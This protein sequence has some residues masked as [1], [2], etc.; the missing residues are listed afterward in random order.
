M[1]SNSKPLTFVIQATCSRT[2]ARVGVIKFKDTRPNREDEW[3]SCSVET[4][5]FMPVGTAGTMKGLLPD[6]VES[7]G[8]R[9]MLSNT[10]HLAARPGIDVIEKAGGLHQYMKWPHA[11]LTDSGGFQMVSLS[12]L[13]DLSEEGVNF[14]SPY[15]PGKMLNLPPEESIRVQQG[16]GSNIMMQLDDVVSA[17][18]NDDARY[19]EAMNRSIRWL[20]R[21]LKQNEEKKHLQ[22]LFPIIQGGLNENLRKQ[23]VDEIVARNTF[24]IAI[25][26]LSGGEA[27]E[28]FVDIVSVSTKDLPTDKPRYLMGVGFAVDLLLCSALG[29]DMFDCV[30]PTRT[31]RFGTAL[32][33]YGKLLNFRNTSLKH[34]TSLLDDECDCTTCS[35]GYSRA[36][37]QS[38]FQDKNDVGCHLLTVHNI[39]FQMRFMA[40]IR[41]SIRKGKFVEHIY[42]V[43][44]YHFETREKYPLF[45]RKALEVL[46][47][48]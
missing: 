31:A 14:E 45:V 15:E 46:K 18:A 28:T 3:L 19:E 25:G 23:S 30:Y 12:S 10:Y 20:D 24:G 13:M 27:K 43:L 2:R 26:G 48:S 6:Q 21:C 47:I 36:Y 1:A 22:A 17:T 38:L 42:Q 32:I 41:E 9:L 16:L 8:C 4:P 40:S 33:G 34:D 37:I 39:R 35:N 11:L 5:V 29:C 7:T 44:D